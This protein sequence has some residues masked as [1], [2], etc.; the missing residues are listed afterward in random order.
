MT[1]T[2]GP[3]PV[4]GTQDHEQ[5]VNLG[6]SFTQSHPLPKVTTGKAGVTSKIL[7]GQR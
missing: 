4:T 7:K 6:N 5:A 2:P 3:S 1:L